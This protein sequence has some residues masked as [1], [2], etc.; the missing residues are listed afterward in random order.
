MNET[1]ALKVG[2][3]PMGNRF[4]VL[5]QYRIVAYRAGG[6]ARQERRSFGW[7]C[8]LSMPAYVEAALCLVLDIP[9]TPRSTTNANS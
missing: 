5:D 6:Y 4:A 1:R 3:T 7:G 8:A 2:T 9:F